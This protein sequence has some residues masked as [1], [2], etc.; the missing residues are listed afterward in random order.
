MG[1]FQNRKARL[2]EDRLAVLFEAMLTTSNISVDMIEKENMLIKLEIFTF[3][4]SVLDYSLVVNKVDQN[5]REAVNETFDEMFKHSKQWT[6]LPV[7]N[8]GRYINDRLENYADIIK[9]S[10]GINETYYQRIIEYQTQ[11]IA[12]IQKKKEVRIGFIAVPKTKDDY[13][14]IMLDATLIFN[15]KSGLMQAYTDIIIKFVATMRKNAKGG[16]FLDK[17]YKFEQ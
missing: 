15:I 10:K 12:W 2:F 8:L 3:L 4:F 17:K 5:I 9:D 1:F 7:D 6:D 11:L 16:Y 13:K 14:P